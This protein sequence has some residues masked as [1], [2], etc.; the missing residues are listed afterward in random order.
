MFLAPTEIAPR[1]LGN[2]YSSE[3]S[4]IHASSRFGTRG[5]PYVHGKYS[6]LLDVGRGQPQSGPRTIEE[7]NSDGR[8][9]RFQFHDALLTR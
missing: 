9:R 1:R 8:H 2:R 5:Y 3:K 7:L 4:V 6:V